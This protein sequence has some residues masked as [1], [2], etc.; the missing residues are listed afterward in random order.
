LL[1]VGTALRLYGLG[2]ESLWI[3]E[4]ITVVLI[5]RSGPLELLTAVPRQQPH[6][7]TYYVLLDL[8]RAVTGPSDAALRAFSA[9]CSVA[10]LPFVYA[11]GARLFDRRA[12]LLALAVAALSRF[13]LAYGQEIRMYALLMLLTTA[14]F[15]CLLRRAERRWAVAYLCTAVAAAYVHPFGGLGVVGGLV[16]LAVARRGG[17]EWP[18]TAGDRRAPAAVAL[19]LVPL[20][21]AAAVEFASGFDLT[22]VPVPGPRFVALAL[23]AFLGTW[24]NAWLGVAAGVAFA[25]AGVVAIAVGARCWPD[26]AAGGT[27]LVVVGL[28]TPV[29]VLVAVSHLLTP[30]FWPRYVAGA[31]PAAYLLVGRGLA[32]VWPAGPSAIGTGLI[33]GLGGSRRAGRALRGVLV[34]LLL[35]TLVPS[36]MAYHTTDQHEEWD[37]AVADIE[38]RASSDALVIVDNCMTLTAYREYADRPGLDVA[39]VVGPEAGMGE[40]RTPDDRVREIVRDRSEVWLVLSHAVTR[41]RDRMRRI[42]DE[43]HDPTWNRSYVG[44]EVVRYERPA[45]SDRAVTADPPATEMDCHEHLL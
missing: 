36:T 32:L 5:R 25:A 43:R 27:L 45:V 3:D 38:S 16:Y 44:I 2:A 10:T 22:F 17:T 4:V 19:A 24:P 40:D 23:Q 21:A 12:G 28:A 30:V 37:R 41:E 7:P 1:S 11:I 13:Q 35:L 39:G 34:A 33:T 29:L 42:L 20:V 15:Y 9:V 18:G 8:W 14:S 31:A 26:R 6:L